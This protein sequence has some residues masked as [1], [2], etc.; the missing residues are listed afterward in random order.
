MGFGRILVFR[1]LGRLKLLTSKKLPELIFTVTGN[2]TYV[3][4]ATLRFSALCAFIQL[5][6]T[7]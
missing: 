1:D 5:H 3:V 2:V 6:S 4:V 7:I